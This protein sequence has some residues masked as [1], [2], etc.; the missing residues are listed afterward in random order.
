MIRKV[1]FVI[2]IYINLEKEKDEISFNNFTIA[3]GWWC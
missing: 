3:Y 2:Y 1:T